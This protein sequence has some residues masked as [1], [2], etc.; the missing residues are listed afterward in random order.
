MCVCVRMHVCAFMFTC[1]FILHVVYWDSWFTVQSNLEIFQPLYFPIFFSLPLYDAPLIHMINSFLL[2]HS[3][4]GL[5]FVCWFVFQFF[6][7]SL[8]FSSGGFYCYGFKFTDFFY[9]L[10]LNILLILSTALFMSDFVLFYLWSFIW[11]FFY[12]FHFFLHHVHVFFLHILEQIYNSFKV[13][14]C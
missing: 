7:L 4:L 1:M 12:S 6:F 11:A 14:V 10:K 3:S 2:F 8:Y 9:L 5:G 13:L